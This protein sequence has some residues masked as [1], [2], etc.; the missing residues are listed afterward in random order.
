M[1]VLL[2][3]SAMVLV[4]SS[5]DNAK[6]W[7]AYNNTE[8]LS[9]SSTEEVLWKRQ[10]K[11]LDGVLT[12]SLS[13][14]LYYSYNRLTLN[15]LGSYKD[16]E[17]EVIAR[18]GGSITIQMDGIVLLKT[19]MNKAKIMFYLQLRQS[20]MTLYSDYQNKT[21][22]KSID[23][24]SITRITVTG[25]SFKGLRLSLSVCPERSLCTETSNMVVAVGNTVNLDCTAFG[26]PPLHLQWTSN[27]TSFTSLNRTSTNTEI[28]STRTISDFSGQDA[29][30]YTCIISNY[31]GTPILLKKVFHVYDKPKI[32]IGPALSSTNTPSYFSDRATLSWT[33]ARWSSF[34]DVDFSVENGPAL[35]D[36]KSTN[37]S[38]SQYETSGW[39]LSQ[40]WKTFTFAMSKGTTS[41]FVMKC[42]NITI[43][44]KTITTGSI[45]PFDTFLF[46]FI[47]ALVA[48]LALLV[49][50]LLVLLKYSPWF[51]KQNQPKDE[52]DV[53][54]EGYD[55]PP[56]P[57]PRGLFGILAI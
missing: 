37:Y 49:A 3:V 28:H 2:L 42:S 16:F 32:I 12:L 24:S 25:Y 9:L 54:V 43:I 46:P 27:I 14:D 1:R 41:H 50:L 31:P 4:C 22:N 34:D 17:I 45:K 56:I 15:F 47:A 35:L 10:D 38:P 5:C 8:E 19:Y 21:A 53:V 48:A 51:N 40:G 57:P 29:G 7:Y 30:T 36:S 18:I 39:P 26:P 33:L 13:G 20:S 44:D 11:A 23:L 6:C 55:L 52:A